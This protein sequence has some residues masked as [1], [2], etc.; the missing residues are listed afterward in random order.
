M[1]GM[2][3]AIA[4]VAAAI[5]LVAAVGGVIAYRALGPHAKA[6]DLPAWADTICTAQATYARAFLGALDNIDPNTLELEARKA[7]ATRLDNT[8]LEATQGLQTALQGVKP[9]A[10]AETY[11]K[12]LLA[13]VEQ[14]IIATKE[15]LDAVAKATTAQQI[16]VANASVQFRRDSS[17]QD[18]TAALESVPPDVANA[19]QQTPSCQNI[20]VPVTP[21][22]P[23]SQAPQPATPVSPQATGTSRGGT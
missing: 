22:A 4:G 10:A 5:V 1:S 21:G 16:A 3:V 6:V 7:R 8:E 11:H 9:P 20:P 23:G 17:S 12:A 2:R 14:E 13:D 18:L 15:H 19:L